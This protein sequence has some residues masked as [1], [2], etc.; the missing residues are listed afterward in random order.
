MPQITKEILLPQISFPIIS[1]QTPNLYNPHPL[2]YQENSPKYLTQRIFHNSS[3]DLI[4]ESLQISLTPFSLPSAHPS[5]DLPRQISPVDLTTSLAVFSPSW[6]R[7]RERGKRVILAIR[8]PLG[9]DRYPAISRR[10]REHAVVIPGIRVY[11]AI[12]ERGWERNIVDQWIH[13][14]ERP[15]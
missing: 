13:D 14:I 5:V 7:E 11:R 6:R 8:Y 2:N 1:S 4:I 3:P 9:F 12:T 10:P 15:R